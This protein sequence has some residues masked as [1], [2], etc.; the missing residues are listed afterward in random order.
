[1]ANATTIITGKISEIFDAEIVGNNF[2]KRVFY[3]E[4]QG[5]KWP[6]T[7]QLELQQGKCNDLD[8][9]KVGEDVICKVEIKGRK[10]VSRD[11]REMIFTTLKVNDIELANA[12]VNPLPKPPPAVNPD[13]DSSGRP[14]A[15]YPARQQSKLPDHPQEL[16]PDNATDN[17]NEDDDLP[18]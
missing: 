3:I 1:M 2:E 4:E 14:P 10:W 8:H 16:R 6:N 5:S 15:T 17:K 13:R 7:W 9:Y 12:P 11:G 18:F